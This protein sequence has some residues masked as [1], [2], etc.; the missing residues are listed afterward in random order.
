[1]YKDE[2]SELNEYVKSISDRLDVDSGYS[3]RA[4][5]SEVFNNAYNIYRTSENIAAEIPNYREELS[6]LY[7]TDNAERRFREFYRDLE[8]S[9]FR[10]GFTG[11]TGIELKTLSSLYTSVAHHLN[12]LEDLDLDTDGDPLTGHELRKREKEQ[13]VSQLLESLD[14]YIEKEASKPA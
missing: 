7:D 5:E 8:D 12:T 10:Q 6:P 14:S 3:V 4:A 2:I 13:Y 11:F 1:M 9:N